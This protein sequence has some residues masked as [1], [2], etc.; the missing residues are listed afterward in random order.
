M[1]ATDFEKESKKGPSRSGRIY[2]VTDIEDGDFFNSNNRCD[3][4]NDKQQNHKNLNADELNQV[5]NYQEA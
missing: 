1:S 3:D 5:L 4:D 2:P